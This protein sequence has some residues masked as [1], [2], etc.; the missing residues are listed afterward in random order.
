M[1]LFHATPA[2]ALAVLLAFAAPAAAQ[3][4][5]ARQAAPAQGPQRIGDWK[6]VCEPSA[7]CFMSQEIV[8]ADTKL[9]V[10]GI[11]LA[12]PPGRSGSVMQI[13]LAPQID[14]QKPI[15]LS[16]DGSPPATLPVNTC[17]ASKCISRASVPNDVLDRLRKGKELVLTFGLQN[18]DQLAAVTFSL[19]GFTAAFKALETKRG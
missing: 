7:P 6:L 11:A 10:A 8:D 1:T 5:K 16:V 9:G 12:K 13:N 14:P 17:D 4:G 2:A 19:K 3:Q 18:Q 15:G